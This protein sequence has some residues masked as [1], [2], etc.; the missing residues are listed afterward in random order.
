MPPVQPTEGVY[1]VHPLAC[2]GLCQH[3]D[4]LSLEAFCAALENLY[5]AGCEQEQGAL[6]EGQVHQSGASVLISSAAEPRR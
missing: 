3:A 2:E 6:S 5:R 1:Q 4:G